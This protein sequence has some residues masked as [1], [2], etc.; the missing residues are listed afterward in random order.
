MTQAFLSVTPMYVPSGWVVD[1]LG[2]RRAETLFIL[3]WSAANILTGWARGLTSL[4]TFRGL[5][6]LGE[7]GHDAASA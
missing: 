3:W 4:A 2:P 5:L 1:R 6:G 7:P